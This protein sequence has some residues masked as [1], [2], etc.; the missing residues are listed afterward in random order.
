MPKRGFNNDDSEDYND[1]YG[2]G[3]YTKI[4]ELF[5]NSRLDDN[6]E[7]DTLLDSEI[8]DNSENL[9]ELL[10]DEKP[11]QPKKTFTNIK[12]KLM[13]KH[14][15]AHD[16]IF[17]GKKTD[18]SKE[19]EEEY[20]I[21]N[22]SGSLELGEDTIQY[23]ESRNSHEQQRN[24]QLQQD[25][26]NCLKN[27]TDLKFNGSRRKPS[28]YDLNNYFKILLTDLSENGYSYTEIFVELS[29]YFSDNIWGIFTILNNVYK[30]KII[31]ELTEKY[32]MEALKKV[33][34]F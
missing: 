4:N 1:D 12:P 32:G 20:I 29:L 17:K 31:L 13:G 2:T 24:L 25:I 33:D 21:R 22:V 15:L 10:E 26:Y 27:N 14:S 9:E 6:E 8:E 5:D 30:D 19:P 34:F 28:H 7:E 23:S 18:T 3:E 16:N 11:V